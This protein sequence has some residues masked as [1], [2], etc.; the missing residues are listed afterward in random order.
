MVT[1]ARQC[2]SGYLKLFFL[3]PLFTPLSVCYELQGTSSMAITVD[4]IDLSSEID[5][6]KAGQ[7]ELEFLQLVD[8]H[9]NLFQGPAFKNALR[10]YESLWLPLF[11]NPDIDGKDLQAPLD[12]EWM[13]QAHILDLSVYEE[14]CKNVV[15]KEVDHRINTDVQKEEALE[16]A[17]KLW[18]KKCPTE[19]F[20]ADLQNLPSSV[21]QFESKL[22]CNFQEACTRLRTL[23]YNVSLPHYRDTMFLMSSIKRYKEHLLLTQENPKNTLL[24]CCDVDLIW[25]M[26]LLHP[27]I[28]KADTKAIFGVV[29]EHPE[30]KIDRLE[31]TKYLTFEKE[32]K[33][34]WE[35]HGV[36]YTRPGAMFR[37]EAPLAHPT[38]PADAYRRLA[39]SEFDM[40]L[41]KFETENFEKDKTFSFTLQLDDKEVIWKKRLKGLSHSLGSERDPLAKFV[42]N[43]DDKNNITLSFHQKKLFSKTPNLCHTI[44]L[45]ECLETALSAETMTHVFRIPIPI[46]GPAS[47]K[48]FVT[49]RTSSPPRPITYRFTLSPEPEF[50]KFHHPADVLSAPKTFLK[51]EILRTQ[52]VPC[53]LSVYRV[54]SYCG[55]TAFSCRVVNAEPADVMVLEVVNC[56]GNTVASAHL[57]D[58]TLFPS[59]LEPLEDASKCVTTNMSGSETALLIRGCS[60]WGVCVGVK[61]THRMSLDEEQ[62]VARIKFFRLGIKQGWCDVKKTKNS[63]LVKINPKE[64]KI[65]AINPDQGQMILPVDI[66]DVPECIA[67]GVSLML[68]PSLCYLVNSPEG[69]C[70]T[71]GNSDVTTVVLRC[72]SLSRYSCSS[73]P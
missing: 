34:I 17:R 51:R 37:G 9:Q 12:I 16:R 55:K 20:K 30:T 61:T 62:N 32:T 57:V 44:D 15:S 26:H 39:V 24:P 10:R 53:E 42:A 50:A 67:A 40:E 64:D 3:E 35:K 46:F 59:H 56:D 23:Y 45:T 58:N 6:L 22:N 36:A 8:C 70:V 28:Y 13:W 21:Q 18:E 69:G 29:L 71:Q 60:D 52:R 43:T 33:A 63:L 2:T 14:D 38:E 1:D 31:I 48:A 4:S 47:R 27:S 68:L 66:D 54:Y 25:K 65:M 73:P 11:N 7:S 41:V 19:P 49:L 72:P 5:F